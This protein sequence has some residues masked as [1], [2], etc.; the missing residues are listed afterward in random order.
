MNLFKR[1]FQKERTKEIPAMPPWAEI[2]EMMYDKSLDAFAEEVVNVVYSL[3]KTMRYVVLKDERGLFTYQL[4][5]IYKFDE[6]EWKYIC[7]HN[8]ALPAMWEPFPGVAGKSLFEN[9]EELLKEMKEEPA[10]KRYF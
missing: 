4:E 9:E 6:D 3:D 8:D 2:V 5:A 1:L 10:Y 7:F